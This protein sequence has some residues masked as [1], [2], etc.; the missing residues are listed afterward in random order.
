MSQDT[1]V[2]LGLDYD[3]DTADAQSD[4]ADLGTVEGLE[5]LYQAIQN[6]LL[7]PIGT[8]PLHPEYGSTLH[9]FIGTNNNP[10]IET[11]IKMS[12]VNAL[13]GEERIALIRGISVDFDRTASTINI[14][15]DI[16]SIYSTELSVSMTV[17]G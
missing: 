7:T 3:G 4:G 12:V 9:S 11:A 1:G 10:I 5:N 8:L 6:R 16:V 17:G 2:D 13:Q 14:I 15:V